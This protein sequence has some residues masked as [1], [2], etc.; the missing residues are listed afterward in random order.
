MYTL[1]AVEERAASPALGCARDEGRRKQKE[2]PATQEVEDN[3]FVVDVAKDR[4]EEEADSATQEVQ[5]NDLVVDAA[6]HEDEK[7]ADPV[8]QEV[9]GNDL[10]VRATK[11]QE[12]EK[13]GSEKR[14]CRITT[15]SLAWT[16][17]IRIS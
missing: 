6:R 17:A 15:L 12:N 10:V 5:D 1:S 9:E 13:A 16:L 8:M 3:E 2:D 14:R 11:H 7:K 4:D